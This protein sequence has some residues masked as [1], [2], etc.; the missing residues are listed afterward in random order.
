MRAATPSPAAVARNAAAALPP[1]V[2]REI[3]RL[4]VRQRFCAVNAAAEA[5]RDHVARVAQKALYW[6]VRKTRAGRGKPYEQGLAYREWW[7]GENA[8]L[9]ALA[10]PTGVVELEVSTLDQQPATEAATLEQSLYHLRLDARRN[11]RRVDRGDRA[12]S[13]AWT[14]EFDV[15][16]RGRAMHLRSVRGVRRGRVRAAAGVVARAG[17]LRA[18]QAYARHPIDND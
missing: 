13:V 15:V 8:V 6:A 10:D 11:V 5:V 16:R 3:R 12:R 18:L 17:V 7:L 1:N 4:H 2:L 9:A 14:G